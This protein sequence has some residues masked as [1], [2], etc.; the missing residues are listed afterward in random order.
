M[1]QISVICVMCDVSLIPICYRTH[2][3]SKV[4]FDLS[5]PKFYEYILV[6]LKQTKTVLEIKKYT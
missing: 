5:S 6:F 3:F 4:S 2:T 1:T